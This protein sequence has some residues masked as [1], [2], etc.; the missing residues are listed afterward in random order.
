MKI[1][2]QLSAEINS[3]AGRAVEGAADLG[4]SEARRSTVVGRAT[5][6]W[7]MPTCHLVPE[8]RRRE[9]EQGAVAVWAALVGQTDNLASL[10]IK[11]NATSGTDERVVGLRA[12]LRQHAG[13]PRLVVARGRGE[14]HNAP[15]A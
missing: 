4:W 6:W 7:S 5:E 9:A 10:A 12:E 8:A 11:G 13:L 15:R 2:G 1:P 3:V 14:L